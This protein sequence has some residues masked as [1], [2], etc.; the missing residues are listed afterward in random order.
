MLSASASCIWK[1]CC[2]GECQAGQHPLDAVGARW[3][4]HLPQL[5][6][7]SQKRRGVS[8][9]LPF[10]LLRGGPCE[11]E[12][13]LS[14]FTEWALRPREVTTVM[15]PVGHWGWGCL[16][17]SWL[18][19]QGYITPIVGA[20]PRLAQEMGVV[21]TSSLW[22]SEAAERIQGLRGLGLAGKCRAG[23]SPAGATGLRCRWRRR[24]RGPCRQTPTSP[25]A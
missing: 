21:P 25:S 3:M 5:F 22:D 12:A 6:L 10:C 16:P 17:P 8:N 1:A 4:G 23:V 7:Y 24:A 2:P 14:H 13:P 11:R 9:C 15:Q 18:P 20:P 19:G